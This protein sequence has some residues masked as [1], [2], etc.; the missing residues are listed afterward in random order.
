MNQQVLTDSLKLLALEANTVG[1]SMML[2]WS[3]KI[4]WPTADESHCQSLCC[5]A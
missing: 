1:L 5:F 3:T 2:E 4:M